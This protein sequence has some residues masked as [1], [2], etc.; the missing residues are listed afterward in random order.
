MSKAISELVWKY[1]M[2]PRNLDKLWDE[3]LKLFL[4]K[5]NMMMTIRRREI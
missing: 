3:E 4:Y 2:K 5:T 1:D